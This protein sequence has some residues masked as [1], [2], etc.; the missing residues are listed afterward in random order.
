VSALLFRPSG[1]QDALF[2]PIA[3]L[4]CPECGKVVEVARARN[5]RSKRSNMWLESRLSKFP[6]EII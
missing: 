6:K 1:A 2:A 3:T 4:Q 5:A